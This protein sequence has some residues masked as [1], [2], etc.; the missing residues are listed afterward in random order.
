MALAAG[1][2]LVLA[3][4]AAPALFGCTESE[5]FDP[6]GGDVAVSASWTVEGAAPTAESCEAACIET[7]QLRV[8]EQYEGGNDYTQD[9][10]TVDCAAGS[11]TTQ[12]ILLAGTYRIALYGNTNDELAAAERAAA[13]DGAAPVDGFACEAG[14]VQAAAIEE[15]S[16]EAAGTLSAALDLS[17]SE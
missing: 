13:A 11:I 9:E 3:T 16:A 12:P 14:D 6:T 4:L 17:P 1:L 15:V 8:W 5:P 2:S 7:V 10:W